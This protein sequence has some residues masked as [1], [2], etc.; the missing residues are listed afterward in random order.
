MVNKYQ[1]TF[2]DYE[3]PGQTWGTPE[4]DLGYFRFYRYVHRKS[5][6]VK[7][8]EPIGEAAMASWCGR[9]MPLYEEQP[10]LF[11]NMGAPAAESSEDRSRNTNCTL[12]RTVHVQPVSHGGSAQRAVQ[13]RQ[14]FGGLEVE[15]LMEIGDLGKSS[16][17]P[18]GC[19]P[20][21]RQTSNHETPTILTGPAQH[22]FYI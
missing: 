11:E 6:V 13:A 5:G 3:I 9:D 16:S 4:H 22:I 14:F 20:P 8:L 21:G 1:L 17:L 18:T 7:I 12:H 2:E 15:G 19:K 10:A